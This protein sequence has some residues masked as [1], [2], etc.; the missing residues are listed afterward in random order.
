MKINAYT[1]RDADG[2]VLHRVFTMAQA[3]RTVK[4][5]DLVVDKIKTE[6]T[7][8][9]DYKVVLRTYRIAFAGGAYLE[10]SCNG[11]KEVAR[12]IA[13]LKGWRA[14]R[15]ADGLAEAMSGI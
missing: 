9:G 11:K 2:K 7:I 10:F 4:R 1:I 6:T 13:W 3:S 15:G 12:A 5:M 14:A 8:H